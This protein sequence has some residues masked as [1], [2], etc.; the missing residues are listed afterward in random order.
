MSVYIPCKCGNP[1]NDDD[2]GS[3]RC[4]ECRKV[5]GEVSHTELAAALASCD[6]Q[7]GGKT[8]RVSWITE[9]AQQWLWASTPPA[10]DNPKRVLVIEVD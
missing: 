9:R 3:A 4:V 1:R 5:R 6:R 10:K 2:L 7:S 8:P